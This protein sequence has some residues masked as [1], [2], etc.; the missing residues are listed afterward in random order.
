MQKVDSKN[1]RIK[2]SVKESLKSSTSHG[3]PMIVASGNWTLKTIWIIFTI[4]STS[5]CIY[6]IVKNIISY[7]KYDVSTK[8][9]A[10]YEYNSTFPSITI[11]NYNLFTSNASSKILNGT[12]NASEYNFFGFVQNGMK[13][14]EIRK[15]GDSLEKLISYLDFDQEEQNI[16]NETFTYFFHPI[17]GNCYTFNA[18]KYDNVSSKEPVRTTNTGHLKNFFANL[19]LSIDN[20]A[21]QLNINDIFGG[22]IFIHEFGSIPITED[23]LFLSPGFITNIALQ[24]TYLHKLPKPYSSC[25]IDNDKAIKIKSELYTDFKTKSI[26]YTQ[27]LCFKYCFFKY[28]LKSCSCYYD[29]FFS[30]PEYVPCVTSDEIE[31]FRSSS[32][33]FTSTNYFEKY[34]KLNCPLE[35]DRL[36]YTKTISTFSYKNHDEYEAAVTIYFENYIITEI[37]ESE[38]MDM[39]TL[40]SNIGGIAGLFL[41]VSFLSFIEIIAITAQVIKIKL[42]KRK[43]NNPNNI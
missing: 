42:K 36:T 12:Q 37:D 20:E 32:N 31:C 8:I 19:D 35:C 38:V 28:N 4:I 6:L 7:Y 2:E 18:D 43:L 21:S 17:Y 33:N 9:R 29:D 3:I 14:G 26:K 10:N 39:V 23:P 40:I 41:G 1:K 30:F 5:F 24:R 13:S 22:V 15:Y 27:N 16:T 34:C 25:E 11:C